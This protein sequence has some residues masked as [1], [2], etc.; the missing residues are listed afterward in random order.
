M[1]IEGGETAPQ[2]LTHPFKAIAPSTQPPTHPPLPPH[3]RGKGLA[4]GPELIARTSGFLRAPCAPFHL[5]LL[6]GNRSPGS[7]IPQSPP[8]TLALR[9]PVLRPSLLSE[10]GA[11]LTSGCRESP[12]PRG[13]RR[14]CQLGQHP[15]RRARS[16]APWN[17]ISQRAGWWGGGGGGR[18][19]VRKRPRI[20]SQSGFDQR[21]RRST[22]RSR[23]RLHRS[24]ALGEKALAAM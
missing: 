11:G 5:P 23:P 18:K 21:M 10:G 1:Q 7:P 20:P 9:A 12:D 22:C 2:T 8:L 24:P 4:P 16:F 17:E 13:A 3:P 15:G 19:E 6:S 14:T